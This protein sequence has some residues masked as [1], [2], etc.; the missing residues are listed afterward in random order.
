MAKK[1]LTIAQ[2]KAI[3]EGGRRAYASSY[4][5]MVDDIFEGMQ[6]PAKRAG[7]KVFYDVPW[8]YEMAR[9]IRAHNSWERLSDRTRQ[10][11]HRALND[12]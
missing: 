5:M 7:V 10:D 11:I 2:A 8:F 4:A 3:Y 1:K 12:R 9:Q 6:A